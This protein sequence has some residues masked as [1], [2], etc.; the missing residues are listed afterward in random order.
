MEPKAYERMWSTKQPYK[1]PT[2]YDDD[3]HSG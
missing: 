2:S 3:H 1:Q